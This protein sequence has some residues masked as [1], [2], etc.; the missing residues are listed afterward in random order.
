MKQAL[1]GVLFLAVMLSI[2]GFMGYWGYQRWE[3]ERIE[4]TVN[5]CLANALEIARL[6]TQ[7][8]LMAEGRLIIRPGALRMTYHIHTSNGV[9]YPELYSV[10]NDSIGWAMIIRNG[11]DSTDFNVETITVGEVP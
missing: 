8:R 4:K 9:I 6:R 2:P 7:N 5:E 1:F 10:V 3:R 11:A